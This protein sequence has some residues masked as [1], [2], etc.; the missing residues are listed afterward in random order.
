MTNTQ[1]LD[2][3]IVEVSSEDSYYPSNEILKGNSKKLIYRNWFSKLEL[4]KILSISPRI[5]NSI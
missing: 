1:K 2:F 3:K 4:R 5:N